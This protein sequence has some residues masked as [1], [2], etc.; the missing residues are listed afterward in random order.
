[1]YLLQSFPEDFGVPQ[2][3]EM[4]KHPTR[5]EPEQMDARDTENLVKFLLVEHASA[6]TRGQI[7]PDDNEND[8]PKLLLFFIR[9]IFT[10]VYSDRKRDPIFARFLL[11][12]KNHG[13]A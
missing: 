3:G 7:V 9:S 10:N 12:E 4:N 11:S 8:T 2:S 5:R 6:L 13:K 1:M